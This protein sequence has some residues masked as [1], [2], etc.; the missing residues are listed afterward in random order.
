MSSEKIHLIL[1][2]TTTPR[3]FYCSVGTAPAAVPPER[4][5]DFVEGEI[6][7]KCLN[8]YRSVTRTEQ[9][10]ERAS[11]ITPGE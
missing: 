11:K 3:V 1:D 7:D 9:Y 4:L 2:A 6:C 10:E 5:R 8:A